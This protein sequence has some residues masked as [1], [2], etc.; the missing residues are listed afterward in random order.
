MIETLNIASELETRLAAVTDADVERS[1]RTVTGRDD[2]DKVLG[3]V[4][5]IPLR[6]LWAVAQQ[7]K[8]E[9]VKYLADARYR[10]NSEEEVKAAAANA[11]R[12]HLLGELALHLFWTENRERIGKDAWDAPNGIGIRKGW[13]IV[14]SGTTPMERLHTALLERLMSETSRLGTGETDR[15]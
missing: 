15:Q 9:R 8:F 12:A 3:A 7:F 14:A 11:E 13:Q 10:A 2:K 1:T 4:E 6:K 5:S